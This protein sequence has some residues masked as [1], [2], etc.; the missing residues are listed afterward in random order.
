MHGQ[1]LKD[2]CS[3]FG[4]KASAGRATRVDKRALDAGRYRVMGRDVKIGLALGLVVIVVAIVI[5]SV[6]GGGDRPPGT[7]GVVA[8]APTA[9]GG[10][11]TRPAPSVDV[12]PAPRPTV[13]VA[14]RPGPVVPAPGPRADRADTRLTALVP[15]VPALSVARPAEHVVRAG[16]TLWDLA[17]RYYHSAAAVAKI[18]EANKAQVPTPSAPLKIGMRLVLP[19]LPA[20][21]RAEPGRAGTS[22]AATLVGGTGAPASTVPYI[23]RPGDT[24]ASIARQFYGSDQAIRPILTANPRLARNPDRIVTGWTL[25]IPRLA[26]AGTAGS[27]GSLTAVARDID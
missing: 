11:A 4:G 14:E 15:N 7:S 17:V 2:A 3:V 8:Q 26:S 5:F 6:S 16:D 19:D 10:P 22:G 20:A 9:E 25:N 23:V 18:Q 27:V 12:T 13:V 24:L 21:P 1:V